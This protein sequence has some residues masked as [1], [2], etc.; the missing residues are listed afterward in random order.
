MRNRIQR[1]HFRGRVYNFILK[2]WLEFWGLPDPW[3]YQEAARL[4]SVRE[5]DKVLDVGC[6]TGF[7]AIIF[8]K[9]VGERGDVKGIDPAPKRLEKARRRA[10]RERLAI[11]FREGTIENIPFADG[12]FDVVSSTFV[13]HHLSMA[14]KKEGLR[15]I[16][17]VLK[18][19]GR[20]LLV[21]F[22][23]ILNPL[24]GLLAWLAY[25]FD[26][27]I[28]LQIRGG[29]LQFL[30]KEGFSETKVVKRRA[31]AISFIQLRK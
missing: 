16:Q 13:F 8:K 21:D 9:M 28:R 15:E 29:L 26:E 25:P 17:R 19:E 3:V 11:D 30:E 18:P 2:C 23:R 1:M 7:L 24:V 20:F 27:G 5:G 6:G 4:A 14:L 22:D 12:S 31:G 10:K